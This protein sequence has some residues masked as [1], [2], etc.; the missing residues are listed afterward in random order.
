MNR[1]PIF[2]GLFIALFLLPLITFAQEG[3]VPFEPLFG[4]ALKDNGNAHELSYDDTGDFFYDYYI[5]A[6]APYNA[7]TFTLKGGDGGWAKAGADCRSEGGDGATTEIT[8]L[9]GEEEGMLPLGC[10]LRFIAGEA[11]GERDS[12]TGTTFSSGGGGGGSAV[13]FNLDGSNDGWEILA[14]AGGGSG[15]YQGNIFG[16]CVDSQAGEGGRTTTE[17]GNGDDI[18]RGLGGIAGNGGKGGGEGG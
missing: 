8:I 11:G 6:D 15:A 3:E 17:G 4:D 13:L 10:Y 14:V 18:S 1:P 7:I 5:P 12:S 2:F 16:G 9:I